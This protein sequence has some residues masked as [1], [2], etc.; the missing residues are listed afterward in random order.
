MGGLNNDLVPL[1]ANKYLENSTSSWTKL[2][3]SQIS[4]PSGYQIAKA[5]GDTAW[6]V[7]NYT[8]YTLPTWLYENLGCGIEQPSYWTSTPHMSS[9]DGVWHVYYCNILLFN[10]IDS[11]YDIRPVITLS[12]SQLG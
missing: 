10:Y 5:G 9:S 2:E 4:L 3:E 8:G 12:K 7:G 1:T 6:T 11:N